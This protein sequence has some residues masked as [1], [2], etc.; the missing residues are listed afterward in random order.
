MEVHWDID[1]YIP[2]HPYPSMGIEGPFAIKLGSKSIKRK[3]KEFKDNLARKN[4]YLKEL[5]HSKASMKNL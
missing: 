5:S 4:K 1:L 3:A 2:W